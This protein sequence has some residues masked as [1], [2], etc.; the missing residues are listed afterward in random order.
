MLVFWKMRQGTTEVKQ[1]HEKSNVMLFLSSR[2]NE[3]SIER[4]DMKNGFFT[5][6]LVS[7]LR[8]KA[9]SN[10]DR[11]ISAKELFKF[12]SDNVRALSKINN[13]LLCGDTFLMICP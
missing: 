13:I 1:E 4:K 8:G 3:T 11:T 7:A 5:T 6:C 10:R 12:V 2:D 9:D